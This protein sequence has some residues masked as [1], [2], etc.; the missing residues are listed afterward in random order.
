MRLISIEAMLVTLSSD[1]CRSSSSGRD[2]CWFGS[3]PSVRLCAV[4]SGS[5][6]SGPAC[7]LSGRGDLDGSRRYAAT[8]SFGSASVSCRLGGGRWPFVIV[9]WTEDSM[10]GTGR[11]AL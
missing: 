2:R 6:E 4:E 11:A 3:L 7:T 5:V 10:T 9:G 8:A 1:R